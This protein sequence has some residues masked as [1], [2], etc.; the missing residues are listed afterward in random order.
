MF[1]V[2]ATGVLALAS[3]LKPSLIFS[4]KAEAYPSEALQLKGLAL[5]K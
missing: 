1:T 2:Q 5:G 4:R 3:F